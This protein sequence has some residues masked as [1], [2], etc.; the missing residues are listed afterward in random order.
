MF[1]P[2]RQVTAP[3]GRKTTLFGRVRHLAALGA[4]STLACDA[5]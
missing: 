1:R 5:A 4:K 2:V 3:V